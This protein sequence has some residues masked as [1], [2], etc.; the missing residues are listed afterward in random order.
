MSTDAPLQKLHEVLFEEG[1]KVRREVVGN[2]YVDR[3]LSNGSSDFAKP[4]QQLVTE[5]CWGHVWTRPG[6]ERSQRSLLR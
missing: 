1:L 3:S 5:W 4:G 2:S 6:L